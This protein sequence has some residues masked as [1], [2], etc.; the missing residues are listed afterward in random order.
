M[1]ILI[2]I[3]PIKN[4]ELRK[5]KRIYI[6]RKY[7][8]VFLITMLIFN[9]YILTLEYKHENLLT[10][11]KDDVK[12][13]GIVISNLEESEY[14]YKYILKVLNLNNRKLT[15][16]NLIV[17]TNKDTNILEYGDVIEF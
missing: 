5:L 3:I 13:K 8:I 6:K 1:F 4:R 16:V 11:I 9:I 10:D 7:F 12:V 2:Y 14:T 15:N 17:Y